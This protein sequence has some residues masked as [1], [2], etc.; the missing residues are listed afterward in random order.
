MGSSVL[1]RQVEGLLKQI[2]KV[3]ENV[4]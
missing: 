3:E 1:A 2:K 4:A